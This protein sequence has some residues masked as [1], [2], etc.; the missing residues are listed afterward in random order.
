[1]PMLPGKGC[2]YP[3]CGEIV[4]A[5]V[6]Y[7]VD[8]DRTVERDRSMSHESRKWHKLYDRK[9]REAAALYLSR[10]PLCSACGSVRIV[11]AAQVVDHIIPHKG[12]RSLFWDRSNWQGLCK[13]CHDVKTQ[14]EGAWGK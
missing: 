4:A 13:R 14:G 5:G 10:H 3:G 1:M 11:T 2:S 8:H 7:C 12:D 6:T 9:W